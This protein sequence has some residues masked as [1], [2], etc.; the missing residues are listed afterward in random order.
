MRGDFQDSLKLFGA[1]LKQLRQAA[2]L[3][4]KD[5]VEAVGVERNTPSNW[6]AGRFAVKHELIGELA[7]LF[8]VEHLDCFV[9]P[10]ATPRHD[11]IAATL[12]LSQREIRTMRDEALRFAPPT[13]R[14]LPMPKDEHDAGEL[15]VV[16]LKRLRERA[17]LTQKQVAAALELDA[18]TPSQWEYGRFPPSRELL[19]A[20]AQLYGV[21]CLDFWVFPGTTARHDLIDATLRL[22]RAELSKLKTAAMG[23]ARARAEASDSKPKGSLSSSGRL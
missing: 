10:G 23:L 12:Y 7:R 6:E 3:L 21:E 2:G 8:G 16:R 18:H 14:A 5:V 1:R 4:Q 15:F 9:I 13:D 11:L 17:G 20:L 22:P 19:F